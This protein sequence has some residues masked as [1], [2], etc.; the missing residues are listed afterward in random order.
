MTYTSL[1]SWYKFIFYSNNRLGLFL[2]E[3][4]NSFKLLSILKRNH[5]SP[6]K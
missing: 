4:Y 5:S 1:K 3:F 2:Y 6:T